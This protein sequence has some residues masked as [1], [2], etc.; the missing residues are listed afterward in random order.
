[1]RSEAGPRAGEMRGP[2]PELSA[3]LGLGNT[4]YSDD[5]TGIEALRLL[6]AAERLPAGTRL[7][8]GSQ[9]GL[10]AA[11]LIAD[12]GR[13]VILDSVDAGAAPGTVVRLEGAGL[14]GLKGGP[15]VH[16]LGIADLLTALALMGKTP[17]KVVLL[18]IQPAS[19]G[20]G[21]GLTPAVEA[22]IRGLVEACLR[23]L[24]D[25]QAGAED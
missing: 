14:T 20:L 3:V 5:G 25:W 24:E 10:E 2:R 8:D 7:V 9:Y 12:A 4:I 19:L 22:S 23:Q 1:M 13:L 6:Q 18:G 15:S 16:R 21:V 17:A 11:A